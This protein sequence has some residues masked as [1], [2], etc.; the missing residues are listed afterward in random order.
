MNSS[1]DD[2]VRGYQ[3]LR[4]WKQGMQISKSIYLLTNSFPKHESYG[5][6]SQ[7]RRAATSIPANIAEGHARSSTKEYLKFLSIALGSLAECETFLI[8][9]QEL[10]YS[11]SEESKKILERL[12]R[13]G[14]MLRSLHRSLK[15]KLPV[16]T[17]IKTKHPK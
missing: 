13:E 4:V 5:L 12:G 2:T 17:S 14:R 6:T 7:L 9:S 11:S 1:E 8:L 16:K 3:D 15:R 10:G